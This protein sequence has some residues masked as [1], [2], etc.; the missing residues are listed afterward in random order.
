MAETLGLV[1]NIAAVVQLAAEITKLSYGYIRE[2]KNAPK[3]Q[4]QYLQEVS[5]LMDVL[6]RVEQVIMEA[7][8]FEALPTPPDSLNDEALKDCHAELSKLQLELLKKKSRLIRPF[9][10]RELR[11]QIDMLHKF[12]ENFATYLSS[13]ILCAPTF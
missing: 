2:V 1:A 9:Q 4:K 11:P 13:C 7:N 3:I 12:R 8:S 10:D 6:F 5:G